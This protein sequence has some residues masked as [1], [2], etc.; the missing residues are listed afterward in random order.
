LFLLVEALE[1]WLMVVCFLIVCFTVV[2]FNATK[3][4][5]KL[6]FKFRWHTSAIRKFYYYLFVRG[7]S[8]KKKTDKETVKKEYIFKNLSFN[9]T[10]K[11]LDYLSMED[12]LEVSLINKKT[13]EN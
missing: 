3:N 12:C 2:R 4:R 10:S 11:I 8:Q 7:K 9:S 1:D 5:L 6:Y 13:N